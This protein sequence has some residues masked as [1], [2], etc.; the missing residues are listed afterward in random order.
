MLQRHRIWDAG[1]TPNYFSLTSEFF[2]EDRRLVALPS[3][4]NRIAL[5][6]T[7]AREGVEYCCQHSDPIVAVAYCHDG[8]LA[9]A[10]KAGSI[11]VWNLDGGRLIGSVGGRSRMTDPTFL[12][13]SFRSKSAV[14]IDASGVELISTETGQVLTSQD[15]HDTTRIQSYAEGAD[16]H[17]AVSS[18]D[19][20]RVFDASEPDKLLLEE[21]LGVRHLTWNP[22]GGLLAGTVDLDRSL[23]VWAVPGG[24]RVLTVSE[25]EGVFHNI[26]FD[27]N[28]RMM[29]ASVTPLSISSRTTVWDLR[30]GRPAFS[31]SGTAGSLQFDGSGVLVL[32]RG[33]LLWYE[34]PELSV[35]KRQLLDVARD[36]IS[37][38]R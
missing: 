19:T 16:G 23:I 31:V 2:V 27:R 8:R 20:L 35:S 6:K 15:H 33:R 26:G 13:C 22:S 3:A 10:D 9:T 7:D 28:G 18:R 32:N 30:S 36:R 4:D 5:H 24:R 11:M 14:R 25:P 21:P 17:V 29:L 37:K 38:V 1:D 12:S 34:T